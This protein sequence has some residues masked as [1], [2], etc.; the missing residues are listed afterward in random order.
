ML[1]RQGAIQTYTPAKRMRLL[2]KRVNKIYRRVNTKCSRNALV[3]GN[4]IMGSGTVQAMA[5]RDSTVHMDIKILYVKVFAYS[6]NIVDI[7]LVSTP[8]TTA[9]TYAQFDSSIGG[10]LTDTAY[11]AGL[12]VLHH[13]LIPQDSK[14]TNF[15]KKVPKGILIPQ[16]DLGALEGKCLWLL[17]K[18][19]TGDQLAFSANAEI[20]YTRATT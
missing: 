10:L 9:P 11:E 13:R 2:E 5:L 1:K 15:N 6:S 14:V 7:Y 19:D 3:M 16:S 17:V 8:T 18:N 12:R 20:W 4:A